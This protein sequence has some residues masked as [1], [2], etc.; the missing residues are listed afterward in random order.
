MFNR[1]EI[2]NERLVREGINRGQVL[3]VIPQTLEGLPL[4][5]IL[6]IAIQKNRRRSQQSQLLKESSRQNRELEGFTNSLE[7]LVEERTLLQVGNLG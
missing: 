4:A 2:L 1:A 7:Q 3:R 6:D 5:D